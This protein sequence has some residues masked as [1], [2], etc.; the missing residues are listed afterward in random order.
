MRHTSKTIR[1]VLER[2]AKVIS[3]PK[4]ELEYTNP[5]TLLVAVVLSAQSTDKGVNKAT[6]HLF[7]IADTPEKMLALGEAKLKDHIKTINFNNT[8]AK[9]VIRLSEAL[10]RDHN[11][12]IPQ[13]RKALT[14][15]PGVGEKT[16]S[17]VLNTVFGQ[18]TI[19]VDT[20]VFRVSH[21]L[22]IVSAAADTPDK[23]EAE[24]TKKIPLDIRLNAHHLLILHGRYTCKAGRP[25]CEQ[26]P[27]TDL[28]NW[29]EK[30]QPLAKPSGKTKGSRAK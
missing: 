19:A 3:D 5:F 16:A 29:F 1:E 15:L 23:V 21:R 8:K 9:N 24:L 30:H 18:P 28:C 12:Q 13:D 11:S 25:L 10:V 20:H 17:V 6:A 7:P 27:L 4:T 2:L 22:G 26:C 14:K